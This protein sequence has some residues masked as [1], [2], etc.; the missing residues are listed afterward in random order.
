M[1]YSLDQQ[2]SPTRFR[3]CLKR[4]AGGPAGVCVWGGGILKLALPT[5]SLQQDP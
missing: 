4:W 3:A 2:T 5:R 1:F